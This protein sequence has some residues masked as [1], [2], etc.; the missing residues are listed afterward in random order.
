[1][2]NIQSLLNFLSRF[3]KFLFRWI[4]HFFAGN[5][6]KAKRK[7]YFFTK[8]DSLPD[9]N[10]Q[11]GTPNLPYVP[12][13]EF[14][15]IEWF[16]KLIEIAHKVFENHRSNRTNQRRQSTEESET[17]K[18]NTEAKEKF[19]DP[20]KVYNDLNVVL[21]KLVAEKS[22]E[23]ASM[24]WSTKLADYNK[25]F[26]ADGIPLPDI[27]THFQPKVNNEGWFEDSFFANLRTAGFNPMVIQGVSSVP[28]TFTGMTDEQY[29]TA[30]GA[31][32]GNDTLSSAAANGRLFYC[33]Y[34]I[35]SDLIADP[36][37]NA[38][39]SYPGNCQK[40][41]YTPQALFVLPPTASDAQPASLLPVAIRLKNDGPLFYPNDP[42]DT[43]EGKAWTQ[44]KYVV[45]SADGNHHE[46][47]SHLGWTHLVI[48]PFVVCTQ[49]NLSKSHQLYKL[50]VPHFE[51]TIFINNL[52]AS[53]LIA[54][55]GQVD[56]ILASTIERDERLTVIGR[57]INASGYFR[58][59]QQ[60]V[61]KELA[62]RNV[63]SKKLLFPYRDD[64]L[65]VSDAIQDWVSDYVDVYYASDDD[66]QSDDQLQNWAKELIST[67]DQG[68]QIQD[69]GDFKDPDKVIST[70]EYLKE[71]LSLI[72]F[73][74]SAQHAAV[75]FAQ[76]K[77]M[78][79]VPAF[80][81]GLYTQAPDTIPST[82]N[83]YSPDGVTP[84][85]LTPDSVTKVQLDLLAILGGVYY[86]RLGQYAC[87]QFKDKR[88]I[89]ALGRFQS[90]L[91]GIG[92]QIRNDNANRPLQYPYLIPSQIPQSINV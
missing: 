18:L 42:N 81:G 23:H 64:A 11:N 41:I 90:N 63:M 46:L 50:L 54:P 10:V 34:S 76:A 68:G 75:N 12:F 20:V 80:P 86:T 4:K 28:S 65:L 48:E 73:T 47:F 56:E 37:T 31:G 69:F 79:Y 33:D 71:A 16:L 53:K 6:L 43:F 77:L 39:G 57:T 21:K 35:L 44:A 70:K 17:D 9:L 40:Y 82:V 15:K 45:N 32:F 78:L 84:G 58:F 67:E 66:V 59:N 26:H 14:P 83:T 24:S 19:Q 62:A 88:V 87:C 7:R 38:G 13:D 52:A 36:A 72:I 30:V 2:P 5:S 49:R 27:N 89:E 29:R 22:E 91:E 51:G 3:F 85:L 74:S 61:K 60:F 8:V 55:D 25:M 92:A 1:M